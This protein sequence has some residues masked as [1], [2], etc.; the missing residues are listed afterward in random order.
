MWE[1]KRIFLQKK[2][3][4]ALL[5]FLLFN[6]ALFWHSERDLREYR[7]AMNA[8]EAAYQADYADKLAG[9][10]ENAAKMKQ[11]A[12]MGGENNFS[13]RNIDK[14]VADF[15]LAGRVSL[16]AGPS[17][18]LSALTESRFTDFCILAFLIVVVLVIIEEQKKGLSGF[19]FVTKNGRLPVTVLRF[20]ALMAASL[21]ATAVF[22]LENICLCVWMYGGLGSLGRAVQSVSLFENVTL[23]ISVGTYLLLY[24]L[25]KALAVGCLA[26]LFW[27]LSMR[28]RNSVAAVG[29]TALLLTAEYLAYTLIAPQSPLQ[30]LKYL[31]LFGYLDSS[32]Y[33]RTYLNL[34]L[35]GYPVSIYTCM[36]IL[37]PVFYL[38]LFGIALLFGRRYPAAEMRRRTRADRKWRSILGRSGLFGQEAYKLLWTQKGILILAALA[39]VCIWRYSDEAVHYDSDLQLYV[40]YMEIL[41]GPVLPEKHRY[42]EGE[43]ETLDRKIE[44]Q[45][46][47]LTL[48]AEGIT[49]ITEGEIKTAENTIQALQKYRAVTEQLLSHTERLEGLSE[50]GIRGYYVNR[51]GY[52]YL[53]D[54]LGENERTADM[55]LMLFAVILLFSGAQAW[56]RE[57]NTAD[58]MASMPCGRRSIWLRRCGLTAILTFLI[59]LL[60]TGSRYLM[61]SGKFGF[62]MWDA[63]VQSLDR[64]AD[65]SLN[66]SILTMAVLLFFMQ[67]LLLFCLALAVQLISL[68]CRRVIVSMC[69]SV[70]IFLLPAIGSYAGLPQLAF[71]SA[72]GVLDTANFWN[73]GGSV[74]WPVSVLGILLVGIA[75]FAGWKMLA[76]TE[77]TGIERKGGRIWSRKN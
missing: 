17:A 74:N 25:W 26:M 63:P 64:F 1:W 54:F 32:Y 56:E 27:L 16:E 5:G 49:A 15:Q 39:A 58:Y 70:L 29:G 36:A 4:V 61:A 20:T 66:I 55:L 7:L 28:F 34:N 19:I 75:G 59:C 62:S 45:E 76:G 43:V 14:T 11:T 12:S 35:F 37:L 8:E 52:E 69:V 23:E 40:N 48:A 41:Q 44:E 18:G 22:L 53:W 60:V 77:K 73:D 24:W 46:A 30:A 68:F 6:A 72:A 31:N 65:C 57:Q 3:I 9:I 47:L 33:I 2:I 38:F 51:L 42:P 67:A 50:R 10:E 13:V 21:T 71:L